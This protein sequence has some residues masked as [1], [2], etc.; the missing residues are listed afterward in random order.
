M[1]PRRD[2]N[3]NGRTGRE[4]GIET[5]VTMTLCLVEKVAEG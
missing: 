3:V 4:N 1:N 5:P 2:E